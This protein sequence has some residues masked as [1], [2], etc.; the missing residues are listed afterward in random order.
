MSGNREELRLRR[1]LIAAHKATGNRSFLRAAAELVR[2]GGQLDEADLEGVLSSPDTSLR[3]RPEIADDDAL[4]RLAILVVEDGKTVWA[5]ANLVAA[6][7]EARWSI[8]STAARLARKFRGR[9][10]FFLIHAK[11]LVR[12]SNLY[13]S[14]EK[15]RSTR[16]T[17]WATDR[18]IAG[19]LRTEPS[20]MEQSL[21][22]FAT[23]QRYGNRAGSLTRASLRRL[24][25][26]KAN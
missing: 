23:V 16:T 3:G 21:K 8:Q 25:N 15:T 2:R 7:I 19:A 4:F 18:A 17:P 10:Q 9:G 14:A 12:M 1:E 11:D 5:A 26:I 13:E 20:A 6:E 24:N 22:R